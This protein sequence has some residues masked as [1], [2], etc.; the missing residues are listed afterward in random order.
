MWVR[1]H[2][3]Y[4]H[5]PLHDQDQTSSPSENFQ[6]CKPDLARRLGSE[7]L[8]AILLDFTGYIDLAGAKSGLPTFTFTLQKKVTAVAN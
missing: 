5:A 1:Q 6:L 3:L 8:Q 2:S 4:A 7:Q